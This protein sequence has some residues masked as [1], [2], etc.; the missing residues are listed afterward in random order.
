MK[1][2]LLTALLVL[3]ATAAHAHKPSDSY[4]A[5]HAESATLTGQWDIALRDLDDAIGLDG[6]DDA[7]ITWSELRDRRAAIAAYAL[8]RLQI[9][10]DGVACVN[11][12]GDLLVDRRTDGAY[13]VLRFTVDCPRAP[14]HL[15][16]RY[17]LF[18][19][20]D[21]QHRG[22][23]FLTAGGAPQTLL[24]SAVRPRQEIDLATAA[25]W[26]NV[27]EYW[28]AG[29]WR[30]ATGVEQVLFLLALLLP[31][32]WRRDSG[33]AQPVR[34]R[35]VRLGILKV[36]V[37]LGVAHSIGVALAALHILQPPAHLLAYGIPTAIALAAL[38]AAA[39]RLAASGWILA[40]AFGLLHGCCLAE[41][42]ASV[43]LGPVLLHSL[44]GFS[45][46]VETGQLV[47]VG[48]CLGL[49]YGL[50][51]QRAPRRLPQWA[52]AVLIA[53]PIG[54]WLV[55]RAASLSLS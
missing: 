16:L 39:R 36:V 15:S 2:A 40:F 24:F 17:A 26:G 11:R 46:G 34:V 21:P 20:R 55:G 30:A 6:D 1:R 33:D 47:L 45:A 29:V 42:L 12:P 14:Q 35:A 41:V 9:E 53:A 32:A 13:A 51:P 48:I 28:R 19:D 50:P 37:A 18:F 3:R 10:A 5:L 31:S 22:L 52:S 44:L 27:A 23:L 43:P 4:L 38:T 8:P 54:V 7:A 25:G 49:A